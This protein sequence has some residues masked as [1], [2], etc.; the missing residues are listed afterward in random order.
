MPLELSISNMSGMSPLKDSHRVGSY[1][2][3]ETLGR[4]NFG[5]VRLARHIVSG[6]EYAVK[7]VATSVLKQDLPGNLD[8]RREMSI[9]RA[10]SHPNIIHLH[11]V[12]VSGS[13]VY[14]VMDLAAGGD[15]F[16]MITDQG[17]LAEPVARK[18]FRQLVEAVDYCHRHGIYH[19][20]LKPENILLAGDGN[21][22]VTDFGFS[23]MKDHGRLL[24][25]TNCGSPHYCAP[26]VWNGTQKGYDGTKSDAFSVGVI[27]FVLLSGGQPFYDDDSDKLL[28]KVNRCHVKYPAWFSKDSVDLLK[29]LLVRDPKQRWSLPMVKRHP[30]FLAGSLDALAEPIPV[31]GCTQD[32]HC[33]DEMSEKCNHCRAGCGG[34][35]RSLPIAEPTNPRMPV[36]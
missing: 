13:K 27:L 35:D 8:I 25:Q 1:D 29:K 28:Q 24:L 9:L 33:A 10:L 11:E 5:K 7:V 26:E 21:L 15:F 30:W 20:D 4:G 17:R 32:D 3:L 36:V 16:K 6:Q 23:A 31:E 12:M 14:L 19:R 18:Y 34:H 2:L 22:K